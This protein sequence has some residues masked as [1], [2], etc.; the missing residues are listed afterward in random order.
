VPGDLVEGAR[1]PDERYFEPEIETMARSDLEALQEQRLLELLPRVYEHAGLMRKTWD[2][3]GVKPADIRSLDDYRERAPFVCKDDIRRFRD[4]YG[5][6]FGGLLAVERSAL[7][8]VFSTTGTTGDATLYAHSWDR[9]HPFWATLARNLWDI[10]VRPGDY[11]L[12]SGFKIRGQLYHADQICGAVPL[13]V[14]T[15]IGAW[16]EAVEAI[17]QYRPVYATLTGLA[18]PELDHLSKTT[19]MVEVFSSFKGASFAGEPLSARMR[20]RLVDWRV[21]TFVWTSAGD[22]TAAFECREHDGCHAWEDTVLLEAVSADSRDAVAD[23][24]IGELVATSLDN[25]ATPLIRFR[26]DDLIRVTRELCGC[27]RTHA[28]FWP[29]GRKGDETIVQGRSLVPMEIWQ[30]LETVP[31][32]EA[33]VFQLIRPAR[34]VD[35]LRVRVGY[36]DATPPGALDDVRARIEAAIEER[37]GVLP[38]VELLPEHELLARGRGGKLPRVVKA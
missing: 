17:L 26:S 3:A 19:D 24:E 32:T 23:G 2:E 6:P 38:Q 1:M 7:S 33:A 12:G 15:G 9:W 21:E 18:M 13:M 4:R 31:E 11:V 20:Q 8:T 14:D 37:T 22:V 36:D 27:G 5:D 16:P 34:Q 28:R 29:V 10:G 35:E 30:A 25:P